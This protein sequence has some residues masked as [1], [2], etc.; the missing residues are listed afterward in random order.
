VS[1]FPAGS[2]ARIVRLWKPFLNDLVLVLWDPYSE[3]RVQSL[4][5]RGRESSESRYSRVIGSETVMLKGTRRGW[6]VVLGENTE[7]CGDVVSTLIKVLLDSTE[8]IPSERVKKNSI[9]SL[10][11]CVKSTINSQI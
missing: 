9:V 2:V 3:Q 5:K 4:L 8:L 7:S 11:N 1:A 6:L 10:S